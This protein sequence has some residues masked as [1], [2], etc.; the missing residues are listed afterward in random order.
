MPLWF[1]PISG[2]WFKMPEPAPAVVILEFPE[3]DYTRGERLA[4]ETNIMDAIRA[5]AQATQTGGKNDEGQT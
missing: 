3:D 1:D 2:R 5:T 4:R